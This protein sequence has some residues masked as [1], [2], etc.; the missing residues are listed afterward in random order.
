[1]RNERRMLGSERGYGRPVVERPYGARS[2]LY[3]SAPKASLDRSIVGERDKDRKTLAAVSSRAYSPLLRFNVIS[4]QGV[5]RAQG[6]G[7]RKN[8][9]GEILHSLLPHPEG[10]RPLFPGLTLI[11]CRVT[12]SCNFLAGNFHKKERNGYEDYLCT[13]KSSAKWQQ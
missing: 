8:Q 6:Y 3:S 12:L 13:R 1:V 2:L 4:R 5:C 11:P 7:C 9:P 10:N